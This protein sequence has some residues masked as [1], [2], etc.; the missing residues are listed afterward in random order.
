M[1]TMATIQRVALL[2]AAC[3]WTANVCA[4]NYIDLD[5][6][7]AYSDVSVFESSPI[8]GNFD[9]GD[10]GYHVAVG[11]Y[12][13]NDDSRWVYGVKLE[14]QD[15]VGSMLLA[16]RAIDLGYQVTPNLVLNGY[17]GAARYDLTTPA[18]GYWLGLGGHYW[19]TNRWALAAEASY[20]DTLARDKLLPEENPGTG[21]P[22]IFF[23][24]VQLSVFLKYKF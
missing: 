2:A 21:S 16:V 7:L 1:V 18:Y 11:A 13:N 3:L 5:F 22:D 20:G 24:I 12:R 23:D 6:G 10:V 4:E 17:L 9:S 8:D 19:F 14:L 15:V